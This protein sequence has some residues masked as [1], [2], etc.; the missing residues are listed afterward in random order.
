MGTSSSRHRID[1]AVW[2]AAYSAREVCR[3]LGMTVRRMGEPDT[4]SHSIKM[5]ATRMME[6]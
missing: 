6:R 5:I 4:V 1:A 2:R 3:K